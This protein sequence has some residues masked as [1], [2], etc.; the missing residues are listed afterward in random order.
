MAHDTYSAERC[1]CGAPAA[2]AM[3]DRR[4]FVHGAAC[5]T[6]RGKMISTTFAAGR[7]VI[8]V[9]PDAA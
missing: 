6:H 7:F 1:D 2:T 3:I 8:E 4:G 9:I 5:T